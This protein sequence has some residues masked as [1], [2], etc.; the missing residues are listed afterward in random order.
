MA[1]PKVRAAIS[2]L[3][4]AARLHPEQVDDRRRELKEAHLEVAAR[5]YVARWPQ[6]WPELI[7]RLTL[8]LHPGDSDEI[9]GGGGL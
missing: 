8:L 9:G 7:E 4:V 3:A 6:A 5:E 1:E 2:A